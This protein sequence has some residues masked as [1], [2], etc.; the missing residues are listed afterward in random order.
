[1]R[2]RVTAIA[3]NFPCTTDVSVMTNAVSRVC[4]PATPA[5]SKSRPESDLRKRAGGDAGATSRTARDSRTCA[6]THRIRRRD[7]RESHVPVALLQ[8]V[9][10]VAV[11]TAVALRGL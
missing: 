1:M 5:Q 10:Q 9:G 4:A 11:V 7:M 3:A 6:S 2:S 8:A